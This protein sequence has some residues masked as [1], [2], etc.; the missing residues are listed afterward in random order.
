MT[1]QPAPVP[2]KKSGTPVGRWGFWALLFGVLYWVLPQF[3]L[4]HLLFSWLGDLAEPVAI[5]F[6]V[7]GVALIVLSFARRAP[8]GGGAPPTGH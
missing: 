3:G 6:C 2:K 5:L 7:L 4:Q 1:G 8:G